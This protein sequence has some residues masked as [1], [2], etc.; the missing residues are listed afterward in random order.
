MARK[1]TY[2]NVTST[3]A[4]FIALAGGVAYGAQAI[5]NDSKDVAAQS[6]ANSDVKKETLKSNRLK[7]GAAVSGSDVVPNSLGGA[8]VNEGDLAQVPAAATAATAANATTATSAQ[9]A[10]NAADA[11]AL[12][13]LTADQ[14]ARSSQIQTGGPVRTDLTAQT[15][16]VRLPSLGVEV[17]TDG[18]A[19]IA[20]D[21]RVLNTNPP[22]GP[23]YVVVYGVDSQNA[24]SLAPGDNDEFQPGGTSGGVMQIA[25]R[26]EPGAAALVSCTFSAFDATRDMTCLAVSS[27]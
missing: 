13:G 4:L 3:L 1:L 2:A 19:D 6:I 27:G 23:T 10:A 15:T 26:T 17:R 5:V 7:N 8:A 11:A 22:G 20:S 9:N 16:V 18:D 14:F 24:F 21:L 25:S 12:S